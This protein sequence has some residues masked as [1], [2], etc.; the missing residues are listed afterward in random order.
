[1]FAGVAS[2]AR[3]TAAMSVG[4]LA[5]E[6]IIARPSEDIGR[7]KKEKKPTARP[8]IVVDTV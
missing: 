2:G 3:P 7:A 4:C 5:D 1:V 8:K 6:K